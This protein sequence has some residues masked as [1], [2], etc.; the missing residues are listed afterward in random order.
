MTTTIE[1]KE[2][3]AARNFYETIYKERLPS[4]HPWVAGTASPELIKLVWEQVLVPGM[5]VLEI[6][7]GIGTESVFMATR[8]MNVTGVDLSESAIEISKKLADLYGVNINFQQGDAL[9]LDFPDN[10]FDV[11]CDQGVFH[12]LKDEERAV[13]AQSIAR[14]LK[15]NGLLVLRCFSDKIPGGPQPRRVSSTELLD[16]LLPYFKLEQLERVLSF[17]TP[18]RQRPLGWSTLWYKK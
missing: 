11:L 5:N 3:L 4:E 17:S 2:G 18:L 6:G 12:H 7:S 9:H 13:Y 15:P 14:V 8:G 16:T 1:K 10:H